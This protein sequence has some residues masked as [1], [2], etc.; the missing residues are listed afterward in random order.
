[1]H[2]FTLPLG[3]LGMLTLACG[4]IASNP[5]ASL[6]VDVTDGTSTDVTTWTDAADSAQPKDAGSDCSAPGAQC[7]PKLDSDT[8]PNYFVYSPPNDWACLC[9]M[10]CT[11]YCQKHNKFGNTQCVTGDGGFR[12]AC[13]QS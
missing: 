8:C 3:T 1:M 7:N 6:D 2:P 12:C 10:S 4:R 9:G 11:E 13:R 5:D